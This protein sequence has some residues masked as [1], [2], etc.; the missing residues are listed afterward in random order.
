M[1]ILARSRGSWKERKLDVS[2]HLAKIV[3][4]VRGDHSKSRMSASSSL[5]PSIGQLPYAVWS[6]VDLRA[7]STSRIGRGAP[8]GSLDPGHGSWGA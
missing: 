2:C 1:R 7:C 5:L 3:D 6:E 4:R 8:H